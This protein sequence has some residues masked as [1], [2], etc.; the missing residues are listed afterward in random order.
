MSVIRIAAL[1]IETTGLDA[2][3]G[4]VLCA[5]AKFNDEDEVRTV[6][7]PRCKDERAALKEIAR[8]YADADIIS[9]WNG[10]MF[11]VPFLNARMMI[12]RLPPLHGKMHKDLLYESKKMRFRGHRLVHA[13]ENMRIP[14]KKFEVAAR[15][16]MLAAEGN[17]NSLALIVKHCQCD[18]RSTESMMARFRPLILNYTR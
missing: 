15:H 14:Y 12:H 10:K 1:D 8:W 7:A 2:T 17:A 13:I 16:W 18:V 4:R 9:T 6:S 11:D 3:Y 5:C